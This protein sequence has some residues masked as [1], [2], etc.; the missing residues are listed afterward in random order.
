PTRR[1]MLANMLT[2]IAE[3]VFDNR[4]HQE[5][6][7]SLVGVESGYIGTAKSSKGAMGLGQ[8]MPQYR[9]DFGKSCGMTEVDVTDLNDDFTNAYLSACYFKELIKTHGTVPLACVAY[10]AG[11]NSI[12]IKRLKAGAAPVEEAAGHATKIWNKTQTVK[13][14]L[15]QQESK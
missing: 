12:S 8:L 6:W 11:G 14:Q 7:L 4:N 10:N 1:V 13:K 5:F 15:T 3:Q 2:G 9:A